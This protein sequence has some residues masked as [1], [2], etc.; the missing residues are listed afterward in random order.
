MD[1]FRCNSV[2][3]MT[4]PFT[5]CSDEVPNDWLDRYRNVTDL[6]NLGDKERLVCARLLMK[7]NAAIWYS[8]HKQQIKTYADFE[9]QF[10]RRLM[11]V[12][13]LQMHYLGAINTI[14][15]L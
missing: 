14:T 2:F 5:G 9:D 6:H 11:T 3:K 15:K 7:G 13:L 12:G 10:L 8:A 1:Y 4:K